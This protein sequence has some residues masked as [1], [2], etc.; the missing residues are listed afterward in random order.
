MKKI[1]G[2]LIL[3]GAFLAGCSSDN[4]GGNNCTKTTC[5]AQNANC[6]TISDGCGGTLPSCGTCCTGL[7]C[8]T[9]TSNSVANVCGFAQPASTVP[10]NFTV[11]D[12]V[13]QNWKSEELEWK[14][15]MLFDSTTRIITAD[16]TWGGPWAK[17]YD[18]GPWNAGGH[19]PIGSTANDHKLGVTVFVHAPA[20]GTDAY[21]YGLRDATNP[22]PVNGGW[23]WIGN[24]GEF[25]VAAGTSAA[26]TA[27]GMAFPA[28]GT[29]DMQV[30]IDT[31]D[32]IAGT[33]DPPV[34]IKGS[35]WGWSEF[36]ITNPTGG[37]YTFTLSGN[38]D[39]A[40][41]PYP[42]LLKSG[43]KP[44]FIWVFNGVEYKDGT[45]VAGL[46]GVAAGTK[47]AGASSFTPATVELTG[48]TGLGSGNSFITVP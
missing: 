22:D 31:N 14:G 12:S 36:D 19:E 24:N 48:G 13:N 33:W 26:V 10:V 44:E 5:A 11:D 27:A 9:G 4:N 46:Q 45:G 37:V 35:A 29:I 23:V 39:Q 2:S 16:S 40:H 28:H 21:A 17:L 15:A 43:D 42:G 38:I 25:D 32:L 8:G 41:P 7:S 30:T 20:T 18:D 3:A 1:L 34:H 47:A 6:G